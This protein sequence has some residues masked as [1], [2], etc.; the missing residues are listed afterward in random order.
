MASLSSS[1]VI[2]PQ[3]RCLDHLG[4]ALHILD[5]FNHRNKNQH[6]LSKWWQQF[7][8]LRRG[9]RK[10][11]PELE[12]CLEVE[13]KATLKKKKGKA[14]ERDDAVRAKME[15]R[16]RHVAEQLV[17]RAFLYVCF[18][19]A[20][21]NGAGPL[22]FVISRAFTQ[23][24]A[25]NQ[26]AHLGLA[27]LGVLAQVN[28]AI[29]PILPPPLEGIDDTTVGETSQPP[30]AQKEEV[31][32]TVADMGVAVSR[33]AIVK[34]GSAPEKTRLVPMSPK[35]KVKHEE[36]DADEPAVLNS[37]EVKEKPRK[38]KRRDEFDDIFGSLETEETAK[39]KK[40]K[41]TKK[42]DEFDDIFGSLI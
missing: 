14:K 33:T 20:R 7:D 29:T 4:T 22:T 31:G 41:K 16:A 23:L 12:A 5:S 35:R 15:V 21:G 26:Y 3:R 17:P 27:L 2:S 40:K 36:D 39:K 42:R 38:K 34:K 32:E 24:A 30:I 28:A 8:M 18:F 10:L 1:N 9:L 13:E 25:D 19:H 37:P 6:R 11:I